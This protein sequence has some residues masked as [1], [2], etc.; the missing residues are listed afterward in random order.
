MSNPHFG[1]VGLRDY[2]YYQLNVGETLERPNGTPERGAIQKTS[3]LDTYEI[4]LIAATQVE[5]DRFLGLVE[6]AIHEHLPKPWRHR[7]T[8]YGLD[9]A[10]RPQR[11]FDEIHW[12]NNT[13][14][15]PLP[16]E[17]L[18]S[19]GRLV[20][21]HLLENSCVKLQ[22]G[23]RTYNWNSEAD[24]V[25]FW[26]SLYLSRELCWFLELEWGSYFTWQPR[27][28]CFATVN[29]GWGAT[30]SAA[31]NALRTSVD[32][33]NPSHPDNAILIIEGSINT[34]IGDCVEIVNALEGIHEFD[35]VTTGWVSSNYSGYGLK[36]L[37][38]CP[39]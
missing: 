14:A 10:W 12:L 2:L 19:L 36:L 29:A 17:I 1:R 16:L 21:I 26:K 30:P 28:G 6:H 35:F 22:P 31:V 9:Q 15:S 4:G 27:V 25:E 18:V 38:F 11:L 23:I 34:T 7:F 5:A 13:P 3:R 20:H 8:A 24:L 33:I 39:T 37:W 32:A